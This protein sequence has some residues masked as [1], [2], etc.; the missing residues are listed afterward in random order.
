MDSAAA[1]L[2]TL[3]LVLGIAAVTSVLFQ[4]LR[5][6]P[7]L[8]YLVAGIAL[9]PHD[10]PPVRA[11]VETVRTLSELGVILL[12]F[13]LGLGFTLRKLGRLASTA[14]LIVAIEVG[15]CLGLGYRR[16]VDGLDAARNPS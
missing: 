5:L 10:F 13:S 2:A 8:G 7:V 15:L 14:G 11:D 9:G 4:R 1:F 6:P 12:M 16:P 3:A